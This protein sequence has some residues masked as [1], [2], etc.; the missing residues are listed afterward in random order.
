[1]STENEYPGKESSGDGL[2]RPMLYGAILF[3][4]AAALLIVASGLLGS[5]TI[6][7]PST[8]TLKEPALQ[9]NPSTDM[10]AME[11]QET[12]RLQSYGWVDKDAGI[13][14][15][16]VDRAIELTAERGLK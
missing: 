3:V 9:I 15:I 6:T 13:V 7:P 4:L 8:S 10:A 5:Q 2:I 11:T 16:P 1:M 12:A 14:R